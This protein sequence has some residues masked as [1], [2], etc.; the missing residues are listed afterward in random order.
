LPG[1]S[2]SVVNNFQFETSVITKKYH[3]TIY[4][5]HSRNLV[6]VFTKTTNHNEERNRTES[7]P[8]VRV[9]GLESSSHLTQNFHFFRFRELFHLQCRLRDEG[10]GTL[11]EVAPRLVFERGTVKRKKRHVP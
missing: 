1:A 9:P 11:E 10:Y 8:S 6:F 3:F 5:F 4:G 2:L 7:A